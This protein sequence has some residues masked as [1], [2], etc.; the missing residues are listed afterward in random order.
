MRCAAG[1]TRRSG[2]RWPPRWPRAT[3]GAPTRPAHAVA[4]LR[5]ALHLHD[6]TAYVGWSENEAR[7]YAGLL[8]VQ[9]DAGDAVAV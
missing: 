9:L 1:P 7:R 8:R 3:G 4:A 2:R 5:I 6:H